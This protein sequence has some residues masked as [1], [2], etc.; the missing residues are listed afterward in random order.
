ML[1]ERVI[2]KLKDGLHARAAALFVKEA[3]RYECDIFIE[4]DNNRINAKSIMGIMSLVINKESEI[5][6]IADGEDEKAAVEK[7][8]NYV[9]KEV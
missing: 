7:L 5:T 4:K 6:I 2:I 8:I 1:K 3:N 9:S